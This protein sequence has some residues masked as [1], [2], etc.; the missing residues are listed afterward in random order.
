MMEYSR[1]CLGEL[2][3]GGYKSA[4]NLDFL[5]SANIRLVV[6]TAKGL[7]T[8][9]GPKYKKQVP[10]S[11]YFPWSQVQERGT[12]KSRNFGIGVNFDN[13]TSIHIIPPS[14]LII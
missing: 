4:V 11:G 6:S 12:V 5:Q 7:D 8:V 1:Y 13:W 3:L 2:Y 9:L 14:Y 10:I